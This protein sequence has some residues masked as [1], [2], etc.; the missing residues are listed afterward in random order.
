MSGATVMKTLIER[1]STV[2]IRQGATLS[3]AESCTGGAL[4]ALFTSRAGASAYFKGGVIAYSNEIKR[5]LLGVEADT[6]TEHGAVSCEVACRMAEGVR[7]ICRSDYSIAVTGIA[8]PD[9]G[10]PDK[11]VGTVWIAVA[12][13][14]RTVA[15]KLSLGDQG[16]EKNIFATVEKAVILLSKII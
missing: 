9:G 14:H 6:L 5:D 2:L 4:A 15:E 7:R 16:R 3:L 12:S 13:S 11:P 1:I 8:G 10:S